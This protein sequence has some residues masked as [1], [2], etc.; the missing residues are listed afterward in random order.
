MGG[1]FFNCSIEMVSCGM[2]YVPSFIKIGSNILKLIGE[3]T[4]SKVML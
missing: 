2:I 1:I 3:N 4:D